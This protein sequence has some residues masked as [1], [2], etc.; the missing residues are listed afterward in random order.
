MRSSESTIAI[1]LAQIRPPTAS[2]GATTWT[3]RS[4][5]ENNAGAAQ[6]THYPWMNP[7]RLNT[8]HVLPFHFAGDDWAP[9]VGNER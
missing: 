7:R 5:C 3:G 4:H 1:K 6:W 8:A 2:D 9:E